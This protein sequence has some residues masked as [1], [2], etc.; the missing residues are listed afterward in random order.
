ME[1]FTPVSGSVSKL[2]VSG[3]ELHIQYCVPYFIILQIFFN[4]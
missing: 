2:Y 4:F 3:S 1:I